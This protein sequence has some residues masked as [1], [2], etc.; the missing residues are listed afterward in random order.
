MAS[1]LT[2]VFGLL[3]LIAFAGLSRAQ[4]T[5]PSSADLNNVVGIQNAERARYGV[6]AF[7]VDP[8]LVANAQAWA[9]QCTYKHASSGENLAA[10]RGMVVDGQGWIDEK[11]V[12]DCATDGCSGVCGHYTQAIWAKS[13]KIGCYAA[14]CTGNCPPDLSSDPNASWE[15][16]VCR[17]GA[18]GNFNSE[19][20]LKPLG[21]AARCSYDPSNPGPT[22]PP[23]IPP[24][25]GGAPNPQPWNYPSS[26]YRSSFNKLRAQFKAVKGVKKLPAL[27]WDSKL[28]AGALASAKRCKG[29]RVSSAAASKDFAKRS[30]K[31]SSAKYSVN[32]LLIKSAARPTIAALIGNPK[33]WNCK[34][35]KCKG[36]ASK[37]KNYLQVLSSTTTKVG[38]A[39]ATCNNRSPVGTPWNVLVCRFNRKAKGG[40]PFPKKQCG[41]R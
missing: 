2:Q 29:S 18:P 32:E 10:A 7:I 17:Y 33:L 39:A 4:F 8:T 26:Q 31:K 12:W 38:C 21:G 14:A 40:R 30:G 34:T 24:G 20:P 19:H 23:T 22:I 13:T 5:G 15:L 16:L 1:S 6:P 41:K 28:A 35:N 27:K 36:G 11:N 25:G 37:C 3:A 9:S